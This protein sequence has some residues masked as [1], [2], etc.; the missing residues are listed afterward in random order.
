MDKYN[1]WLAKFLLWFH[2]KSEGYAITLGQ[3]TYYSCDIER[4][5]GA[6]R[7]H[8]N[9]HKTQ[10]YKDGTIKFSLKYLWYSVRYG[11]EDNPYEVEAEQA[12]INFK[13]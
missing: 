7:A 8:E 2:P 3:T 1:H 12:R 13:E 10:W 11:Y 4:V 5:D 6:W 9:Q